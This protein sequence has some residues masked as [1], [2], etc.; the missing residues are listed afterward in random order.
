MGVVLCNQI[1]AAQVPRI[2]H[3]FIVVEEN[4][5]LSQVI[6]NPHMP[7][8]NCLAHNYSYSK[9]YYADTH[10]SIGNYFAL[11][12]GKVFTNND[13]YQGTVP[14]DNIVRE[15]VRRGMTWKSYAESLPSVGYTA[16]DRNRDYPYAKR[17]NPLA[18]LTDVVGN[19]DQSNH[20]VPIQEL[21]KDI[22][23]TLPNFG[24]VVPNL[25]SDAHDVP[26][27]KRPKDS[28]CGQ[29]ESLGLADNWLKST[30]SPLIDNASFQK[31]GLL[32]VLFDEA[33][34]GDKTSA[35][36]HVKGGGL[37]PL[38]LVGS[39]VKKAYVSSIPYQHE[40]MLRTILQ[41]FGIDDFPGTAGASA[42]ADF[43][44]Q[45]FEDF[46]ALCKD[47]PTAIVVDR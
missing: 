38:I 41:A 10:P 35:R 11:T 37:I 19:T 25:R 13:D 7:Y 34:N 2:D 43:F 3:V 12:T 1:C 6:D 16:Y 31:S 8:L 9:Q 5:G 47:S 4:Q 36:V 24:F 26:G 46:H 23:S 45:S 44:E 32:V 21:Q 29:Q 20:L 39:D 22:D 33:C 14:I 15:L 30:I 27:T 40:S 17:H 28:A 42:M 18:Y